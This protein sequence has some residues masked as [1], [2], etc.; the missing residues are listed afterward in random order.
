MHA[1]DDEIVYQECVN[2]ENLITFTIFHVLGVCLWVEDRLHII[3]GRAAAAAT[4]LIAFAISA[5]LL[6]LKYLLAPQSEIFFGEQS[7]IFVGTRET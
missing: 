5:Y 1:P 3:G 7:E 4:R 6:V 2:H